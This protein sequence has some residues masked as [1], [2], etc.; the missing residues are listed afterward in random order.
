M[1]RLAKVSQSAVSR[2]FTEGASVSDKTRSRVR[3][4][5]AALGYRPNLAARALITRRSGIIGVAVTY[6]ENQF[7]PRVLEMLSQAFARAGYRILLFTGKRGDSSDPILEEVLRYRVDAIV[8]LSAT[9]SSHF[10]AE[11]Q[12]AGIPVV[13]L[14]RRTEHANVSVVTGANH[15]GAGTLAAFL[16]A[17]GHRQFAFMAGLEAASTSRDREVGF[18]RYLAAHGL[19]PVRRVVGHYDFVA[20]STASRQLLGSADRPDALFCAND[21]MAMAAINVARAELGL[22]VG[23]EVS[24]VG[25][26]DAGPAAWPLLGLTT[27]VQP[28]EAMVEEVVAI[29]RRRLADPLAPAESRVLPGWLAVR[30]SARRPATGIVSVDGEEIWKP[31]PIGTFETP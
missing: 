17:G 4:A 15:E 6:M 5:A 13:L 10:D 9:L 11:C 19:G 22:D 12:Q 7:Y 1:A 24:I 2:S 31:N 26:D 18:N 30:S 3:E 28:V 20:A 14:N 8:L 27:Y 16:V 21:H 25:F 29:T 23:R